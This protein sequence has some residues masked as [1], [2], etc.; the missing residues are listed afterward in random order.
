MRI[1]SFI[2]FCVVIVSCSNDQDISAPVINI[3]DY[4][5]DPIAKIAIEQSMRTLESGSQWFELG[6]MLHANDFVEQARDVYEYSFSLD[7]A[8]KTKYLL[9]VCTSELGDYLNA[10]DL[11]KSIETYAPALWRQGFWYLDLGD[12]D[13]SQAYFEAAIALNPKSVPAIVGIGRTQLAT[14]KYLDAIATFEDLI[15]RGGRH[16]YIQY[17][18][19]KAHQNAGNR[20][21][22]RELLLIT[23]SGQP[24]WND[25]W[26]DEMR[27]QKQ[28]F[29]AD[30]NKAV[31]LIDANKLVEAHRKFELIEEKYPYAPEVQSNKAT[32]EL[33]LGDKNK[34]IRTLGSALKKSPDYAPLHLTMAF[35]LADA[36]DFQQ[37]T[38]YASS[39]LELQP[40]MVAASSFLGKL[41]LH[42]N[43]FTKAEE[44]YK[45]SVE[46]GDPSPLSRQSLADL[47]LRR[48]EWDKAIFHFR[49]VLQVAPNQTRSVGGLV[50]ALASSSRRSE[51]SQLLSKALQQYP[52]DQNLLRAQ[53]AIRTR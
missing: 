43:D 19:G 33:Q 47:L 42:A 46:L 36:G 50:I 34:A 9:A 45:R 3:D 24:K 6:K 1:I 26:M 31:G 29:A 4:Q 10:I 37:A 49:L 52:N 7:P 2:L 23:K 40:S 18:L 27:A 25:P 44:F 28:G 48:Q 30:L 41:A 16:S 38:L 22:A 13:Q 12:T 53:Q 35:A 39:A 21:I 15:S 20:E 17:L 11:M 51:A 8:I 32:V 14:S 5:L